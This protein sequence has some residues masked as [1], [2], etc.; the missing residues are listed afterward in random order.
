MNGWMG[1]RNRERERYILDKMQS[2]SFVVRVARLSPYRAFPSQ[3]VVR[4]HPC[5]CCPRTSEKRD[6]PL[7]DRYR[8]LNKWNLIKK[9]I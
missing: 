9:G 6:V 2:P 5:R 8:S 1:E 3:V 7:T 4:L